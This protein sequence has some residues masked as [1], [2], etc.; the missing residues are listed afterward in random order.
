MPEVT[1]PEVAEST[2]EESK[3]QSENQTIDLANLSGEELNKVL[4]NKNL[5][6]LPRIKELQEGAKLAK[7]LQA[8][9]A[10][11][12]ESTLEEQK[13]FEELASKRQQELEQAR[14]ELEEYRVNQELTQKLIPLQV[15]DLD[16]AL[17]LLDRD[18]ITIGD[19]G[20]I[21]GVDEA[22]AQLKEQRSYLF[23]NSRGVKLGTP[24]NS[25]D[26]PSGQM[27]FTR[28][29]IANH[30]FYMKHRDEILKASAAGLIEE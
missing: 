13:K 30:E 24:T 6:S 28:K 25:N 27:K 18:Q 22:I 4:E 16:G 12:E 7:K 15:Q 29:Q 10:K 14:K 20:S 1:V 5:W 17:K 8:E 2:P 11:K 26:I 19:D 21:Q 23:E 3:P 9:Q